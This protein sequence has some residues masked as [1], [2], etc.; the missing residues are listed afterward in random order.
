[1]KRVFPTCEKI[2][3]DYA[4][5]EK[6]DSIYTLPAE[7]GWSDLGSWGSLH[8]LL[9]QDNDRMQRLVAISICMAV[10]TASCI[11]NDAQQVVVEGLNDYIVA[12]ITAGC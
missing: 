10:I 5:M 11:A 6:S 9:P 7:F 8:T 2:S 4:V 12:C 3:I 1:V